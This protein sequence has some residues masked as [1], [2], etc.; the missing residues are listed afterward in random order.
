MLSFEFVSNTKRMALININKVLST[1]MDSI[2]DI[3][4]SIGLSHQS[5][6]KE[7][8]RSVFYSPKFIA[9][10]VFSYIITQTL[11]LLTDDEFV[12]LLLNE[13]IL[14]MGIGVYISI[15]LI[16]LSL[17]TLFSQSVYYWNYKRGIEPTF[18]R[19]FQVMSGSITPSSVGLTNERQVRQL[20]SIAKWIKRVLKSNKFLIPIFVIFYI[21]INNFYIAD[22]MTSYILFPYH[23][24]YTSLWLY[25]TQNIIT[26][27]LLLFFIICKYFKI[28]FEVQNKIIE[29]IRSIN[30]NRIKNILYSYDRLYREINEYNT[31]YWSKFLFSI[32]FCFGVFIVVLIYLLIFVNISIVIRILIFYFTILHSSL[33]LFIMT[34]AS[35]LNSEANKS[36][37]I[38]NSFY[39]NFWKTISGRKIINCLKVINLNIFQNCFLI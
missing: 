21:I 6:R 39:V 23:F 12:H 20:L 38:F 10:I 3:L 16:I 30:T 22:K 17:M 25:H 24:I 33:Y 28:K 29:K 37:K 18:V 15:E 4:Y 31:T 13:L 26:I 32:W 9:I 35:S 5:M 1:N 34:N 2:E 11:S 7:T 27:Q 36:Y 19:V 8:K 14:R